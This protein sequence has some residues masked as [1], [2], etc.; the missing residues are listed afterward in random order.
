VEEGKIVA[1][2]RLSSC[3]VRISDSAFAQKT[4]EQIERDRLYARQVAC[5]ILQ[6]VMAEH[7]G[8]GGQ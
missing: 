4:P 6:R 8:A 2:Y 7:E 5:R 1:E 3:V